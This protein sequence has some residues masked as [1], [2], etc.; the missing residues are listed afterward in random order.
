MGWS[1]LLFDLVRQA[2]ALGTTL[3]TTLGVVPGA[4]G[5]WSVSLLFPTG[6]A[7]DE[8]S[9]NDRGPDP[10]RTEARRFRRNLGPE[11]KCLHSH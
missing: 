4:T 6:A 1:P 11:R 7:A 5:V 8:C 2:P 3:G 9:Q 10:A